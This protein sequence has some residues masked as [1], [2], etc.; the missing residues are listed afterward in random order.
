MKR[1][2]LGLAALILSIAATRLDLD[3]LIVLF[4]AGVGLASFSALLGSAIEDVA[5][6]TSTGI[7]RLLN[8]LLGSA[9]EFIIA[10]FALKAGHLALVKASITGSILANLL[11]ILGM[12][13][14]LGGLRHGDQYFDRQRAT[15][16]ATLMVLSVI[17][18][19]VPAFYGQYAK[20]H[21]VHFDMRL[22]VAVAS[23]MLL[24]YLLA[25]YYWMHMDESEQAR[26]SPAA[27]QTD[28]KEQW[29]RE[30]SVLGL[31]GTLAA[32][33][34]GASVFV[35]AI[36]K[37]IGTHE[38]SHSFWGIVIIPLIGNVA[39]HHGA[40]RRAWQNRVDLSVEIATDGSMQIALFVAPALVF[41]SL[42]VGH[43]LDLVFTP[44]EL[45]SL[46]AAALVATLVALDGMT[47]W[48]E[49]AMLLAVYTL[50]CT[51]FYWLPA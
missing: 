5:L 9:S 6:H 12:G 49:G 47:S 51:A 14:L 16:A 25:V 35:G 2:S 46:A 28:R 36:D 42:L 34:V 18:L 4:L 45:A 33:I 17:A 40:L 20:S 44:L 10:A 19:T 41:L 3:P 21:G 15:H 26:S 29:P 43:P 37:A 48:L 30:I 39:E 8:A 1:L 7:G 38:I 22:S 13:A 23:V 31:L 24:L 32:C 27:E 50:M 11:L